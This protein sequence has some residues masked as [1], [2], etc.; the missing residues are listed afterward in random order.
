MKASTT[1]LLSHFGFWLAAVVLII[2]GWTLHGTITQEIESSRKVDHSLNVLQG[3]AEINGVVSRAE[4]AQ[5]GF[6]L[7]LQDAFLRERDEALQK[8]YA[9]TARIQQMTVDNPA[10][11][12]RIA[13]LETLLA[14]R[15]AIM[16]ETE[17]LQRLQA[18]KSSNVRI[19]VG[20]GVGQQASARIY[21]I[22]GEL[23]QEEQR[24]L[25]A[26]HAE[27]DQRHRDEFGVLVGAVLIGVLVL[28]PNYVVA[29]LQVRAR[30]QT[31]N[32]LRVMANSL[33]GA[34]YQLRHPPLDE[35]QFTFMSAGLTNVRGISAISAAGA[36]PDWGA[37]LSAIDERDRPKFLAA[38]AESMK[39]MAAFRAEYR[40]K[41]SDGTERWLHHEASLQQEKDG[42]VLM[43]GYVA[44]VTGQKRLE[45]A[46]QQ[47]KEA[48]DSANRA[49]S[50][51][52]ATMSHEIRTPMNGVLGMLEL[53]SLTALDKEQRTT[54]EIVRVSSK[55]LLR[56]I[57]DILDFS[58]IEAGKLDVR[59]E[60]ASIKEVI[61]DVHNI[62]TGN[63]SS[64]GVLI[65]R[66]VDP[67]ISPALWVDPLRLRQI[68]NNFVSNAL[69]FTTHGTIEIRAELI[70]RAHGEDKVQFSVQD[71]G[72]GISAENQRRLFQPFSQGEE[73]TARRF[74]GTGLGLT[75]CRRLAGM[76]GGSVEMVSALG[77]G[78]TMHLNLSLPI[79][80]PKDLPKTDPDRVRDPLETTTSMR[81]MMPSVATAEAEGTL[82][83]LVDDHPTNRTLLQRQVQTL[84]YAAETAADGVEALKM[85]RSGRFAIVITDCNMPE[86]DGYMLTRNIRQLETE[87]KRPHTP[88]IACTA[89][90]LGGEAE[91]CFA[92]GMDD[93]LVKPVALSQIL[94]KLTHWL[95]IPPESEP[96]GLATP[97]LPPLTA[98]P[99]DRSVLSSFSG[100][101]TAIERTI[102]ADFQRANDADA[103]LLEQAVA[104]SDIPQVSHAAHRITG[105]CRMVGARDLAE[106]CERISVANRAHDWP[107]VLADMPAFHHEWA[108]LNAALETI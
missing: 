34:M 96:T 42:S 11:Q 88:V 68:L 77:Q 63:A 25:Q 55:S 31:E 3:I 38:M 101:D 36:L 7:S 30:E 98:T 28:I 17:R 87:Q 5:R 50:T 39:S 6:L 85:W 13:K 9:A 46:L 74:G 72:V 102:L 33:P 52:L 89:N 107:A 64:K 76:M 12:T 78:T 60:A 16:Q 62:Y 49:K 67:R 82:V 53:L 57:D 65:K 81:R 106:V 10:Q 15:V 45:T 97:S 51:F 19:R 83:L 2:M 79:I 24:L 32:K 108:R 105:S 22:T 92:A 99:I 91:I 59:A 80:D 18:Q 29:M 23:Q 61:E 47:A 40:V 8:G 21:A 70:D 94:K 95:P 44:D 75:I 54:L 26:R 20:T 103:T 73:D 84:G 14:Q 4:S 93:Y 1:K 86:M 100:G 27:V 43:N 37:I 58:K 71:S 35:P 90:A 41:H 104:A 56:I 69:K 66:S 48:A